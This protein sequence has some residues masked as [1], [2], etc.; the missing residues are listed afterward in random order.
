MAEYKKFVG[1]EIPQI[2]EN[3]FMTNCKEFYMTDDNI[4]PA[5]IAI[6]AL[7]TEFHVVRGSDTLL[8]VIGE[9]WTYGEALSGIGS[10]IGLF[11]L[12]AQLEG[13]MGPRMA[14]VT[15]W[16][17][18][19]FAIPGNCN[20][21]MHIELDRILKHV[22]TLGY[23]QVKV[24]MQMTESSREIPINYTDICKSHP[25]H[26]WLTYPE[27]KSIGMMD[28][29][30]MYD[31]IFYDHYHNS[32]SNFTACPI[33]GILWRNFNSPNSTRTDYCFKIIEPTMIAHTGKLVNHDH[34]SP[35]IMNPIEFQNYF[36]H[37]GKN[38]IVPDGFMEEQ[39]DLIEK[40]FD[41]IGG[42]KTVKC[43]VYHNNHPS[44]YGHLVWAHYL[45]RKA[46]WK[47]I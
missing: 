6:P 2:W 30:A 13:C 10:G 12:Q 21:H 38:V 4:K 25:I 18:Y 20:L 29:L 8:I 35:K 37:Q 31:E 7:N 41:Y 3:S 16:D 40:L 46:G 39:I 45:I 5:H 44:K 32:L 11:N 27:K 15:G 47:D 17:L 28:W 34:V 42:S 33:E 43:L 24:V 19:Q 23:K 1:E 36:D 26:N 14:E 22:S 9:S